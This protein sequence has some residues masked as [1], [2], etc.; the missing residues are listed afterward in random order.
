M[1]WRDFVKEVK[2][3]D[4]ILLSHQKWG[5]WK[6]FESHVVRMVTESTFSHVCVALVE[7]GVAKCIEA[8]EPAVSITPLESRLDEGFYWIKTPDKPMTD[9][10][11]HYG[12]SKVGQEYS[13]LEA[14]EAEFRLLE[15]GASSYWECAEL[16]ICMRKLSNL[17]LGSVATPAKVAE[18][19]VQIGYAMQF[20]TKDE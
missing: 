3:G 16:T 15:I 18:K 10:E 4:L 8:I 13:K 6:D 19:A 11:L 9:A 12:L 1:K 5:A 14:I 2:S 7:G 20:V 17:D